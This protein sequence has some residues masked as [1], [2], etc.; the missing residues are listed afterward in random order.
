MCM[1][2][3]HEFKD[4]SE[5]GMKRNP[6]RVEALKSEEHLRLMQN[7]KVGDEE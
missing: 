2:R 7:D 4:Y 6:D 1:V 5:I 3:N